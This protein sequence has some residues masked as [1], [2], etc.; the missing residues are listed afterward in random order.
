MEIREY[1][2]NDWEQAFSLYE[3]VGW[4]NDT[5][6]PDRLKR[7]L[8][9]SLLRLVAYE[10]SR[11][12]GLLRAVGDGCSILY[13]QDLLVLP[14]RQRRGIGGAL[15]K[16]LLK[17]YPKVYQTVLMTGDCPENG[18]F[19]RSLGFERGEKFRC[20]VYCRFGAAG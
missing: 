20:A 3:D 12:A 6:C 2:P 18:A 9:S 14:D 1:R 13:L 15:V 10:E 11:L 17:R 16:E 19:Y 5:R 8:S 7:A 4:V